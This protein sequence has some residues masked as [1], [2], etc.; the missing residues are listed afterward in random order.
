VATVESVLV[1]R[2]VVLSGHRKPLC[3]GSHW[4]A[5]DQYLAA[6]VMHTTLQVPTCH[7]PQSAPPPPHHPAPSSP[8]PWSPHPP[9]P[10]SPLPLG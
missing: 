10:Q 2:V 8:P 9:P 4:L 7:A 3:A 6:A 1:G 5:T